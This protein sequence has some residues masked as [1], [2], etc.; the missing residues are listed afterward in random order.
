MAD[1]SS[2]WRAD[3]SKKDNG[4]SASS[5]KAI[6]S[7]LGKIDPTTSIVARALIALCLS[8]SGRRAADDPLLED[9][10]ITPDD[11]LSLAPV[12][13]Q[14]T[15]TREAAFFIRR[16][17]GRLRRM[18]IDWLRDVAPL[19]YR[20][21]LPYSGDELLDIVEV[22]EW[23]EAG[24]DSAR[25]IV[26]WKVRGGQWAYWSMNSLGRVLLCRLAGA[27]LLLPNQ[28]AIDLAT[29]LLIALA[30]SAH[31]DDPAE[32]FSC[33]IGWLL[34]E[35]GVLPEPESTRM[36]RESEMRDRFAAAMQALLA[37]GVFSGLTLPDGWQSGASGAGAGDWL[38]D[39][40]TV[41]VARH[42]GGAEPRIE[43]SPGLPCYYG[44][45][46]EI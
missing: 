38:R 41:V 27:S 25:T 45:R 9:V 23:T 46:W 4:S 5:I 32:S 3:L 40:V 42:A 39:H 36:A 18:R 26:S 1:T 10:T 33:E 30:L 8:T 15:T 44:L 34:G 19:S 12:R 31:S 7:S 14:C 43:R 29:R 16:E 11:L 2:L 37:R 20:E 6:M 13:A 28:A 17:I 22:A 24:V 35:A 21:A